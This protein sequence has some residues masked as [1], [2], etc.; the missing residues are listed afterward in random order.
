MR[1]TMRALDGDSKITLMLGAQARHTAGHTER[2]EAKQL[3]QH[4]TGLVPDFEEK[5]MHALSTTE[6]Y[7]LWD[8]MRVKGDESHKR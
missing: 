2:E 6:T 3:I 8:R 5:F 7:G 1:A 4:I